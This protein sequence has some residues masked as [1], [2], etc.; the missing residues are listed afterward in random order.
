VVEV[1]RPVVEVVD[2]VVVVDVVV[3]GAGGGLIRL[4]TDVPVSDP[5]KMAD[6]GL[7]E[8]SSIAVISSSASTKTI[9]ALTAI[10]CQE[11]RRATAVGRGVAGGSGRV[12]ACRRSVAGAS[13][14]AEISRRSV[15][16]AGAALEAIS[17]VSGCTSSVNDGDGDGDVRPITCV[18][19]DDA[20]PRVSPDAPVPPSRRNSNAVSGALTTT[21]LTASCPRS[22]DWATKAVPIVAAAEPMATPTIVPLTPK[23]DAMIAA[24]TAPAVEARIWRNENF[25]Q[26]CLVA[27]QGLDRAGDELAGA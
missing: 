25:T 4:L 3:E 18:G 1:A 27:R 17:T 8:I 12:V 10:V 23:V 21:C 14:T 7:P 24:I 2:E 15:S 13:V 5:P 16:P 11:N 26:G 6:S 20:E 9:T 22:I 19:A